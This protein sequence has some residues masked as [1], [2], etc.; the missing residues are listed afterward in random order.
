MFRM[1]PLVSDRFDAVLVCRSLL[2]EH[3]LGKLLFC[4][5]Y[6][7]LFFSPCVAFFGEPQGT[8]FAWS[9]IVSKENIL[10]FRGNSCLPGSQY[11]FHTS[12]AILVTNRPQFFFPHVASFFQRTASWIYKCV[13]RLNC[14]VEKREYS[15]DRNVWCLRLVGCYW[16]RRVLACLFGS[17]VF[18]GN[19]NLVTRLSWPSYRYQPSWGPWP[20]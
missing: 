14:I 12:H 18:G 7:L 2:L 10:L 9:K 19:S 17:H 16:S 4:I 15:Y 1:N 20:V 5:K 11:Y 6:W 13:T 3:H 8:P